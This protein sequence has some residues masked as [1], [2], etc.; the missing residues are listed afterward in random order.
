MCITLAGN[1][2]EDNQYPSSKSRL[3]NSIIDNYFG[4]MKSKEIHDVG[5]ART[6]IDPSRRQW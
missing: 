4:R 6:E 1:T 2:Q 5:R 3:M